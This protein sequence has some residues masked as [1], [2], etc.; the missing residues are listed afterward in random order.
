MRESY[1]ARLEKIDSEVIQEFRKTKHSLVIPSDLQQYILQI[2]AAFE[3]AKYE[4]S[5]T[6]AAKKICVQFPHLNLPTAKKRYYDAITYFHVNNNVSNEVWDH[7][8]ADKFEDLAKL[9]LAKNK[10]EA[11]GRFF[12]KAHELRTKESDSINPEDLKPPV[13]IITDKLSPEDLGFEN[14][15]LQEIASKATQGKYAEIINSLP[16]DKQEKEQLFQDAGIED[17]DFEDVSNE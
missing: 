2:S 17:V 12:A 6:R 11:A 1:L 16:I 8:Y 14:K 7:Y 3:I 13:F 5:V 9:C 10:D 15:N 4:G